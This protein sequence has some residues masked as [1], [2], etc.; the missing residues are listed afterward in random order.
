MNRTNLEKSGIILDNPYQMAYENVCLELLQLLILVEKIKA[1]KKEFKALNELVG[2]Q[3]YL[4]DYEPIQGFFRSFHYSSKTKEADDIF[5]AVC[6]V[7]DKKQKPSFNDFSI[8]AN[9]FLKK[10]RKSVR[11]GR[12]EEDEKRDE[13]WLTLAPHAINES[14]YKFSS[15]QHQALGYSHLNIVHAY[16]EIDLLLGTIDKLQ[17]TNDEEIIDTIINRYAEEMDIDIATVLHEAKRSI[18]IRHQINQKICLAYSQRFFD[19]T[20]P[21][22]KLFSIDFKPFDNHN[23]MVDSAEE[24][25]KEG[26]GKEKVGKVITMKV[27][28]ETFEHAQ[29]S[30][31]EAILNSAILNRIWDETKE[32][33]NF[34]FRDNA[35]ENYYQGILSDYAYWAGNQTSTLLDIE[36]SKGRRLT[37]QSIMRGLRFSYW[38]YAEKASR[39]GKFNI[40]DAVKFYV[41]EKKLQDSAA[42][43]KFSFEAI[44]RV[45]KTELL[46]LQRKQLVWRL[47]N[48]LTSVVYSF[49]PLNNSLYQKLKVTIDK[50]NNIIKPKVQLQEYDDIFELITKIEESLKCGNGSEYL[51]SELEFA[52]IP[53]YARDH[54]IQRRDLKKAIEHKEDLSLLKSTV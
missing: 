45:G 44:K 18:H 2:L 1:S 13:F 52:S 37:F 26:W 48:D 39:A 20:L 4:R 21:M 43:V 8:E 3:H 47:S 22:K 19:L 7:L 11:L 12:E 53:D 35:D 50:I 32:T 34:V 41:E 23:F 17:N 6:D 24:T 5:H 46:P 51:D 54:D 14:G 15:L 40:G 42:T 29:S 9:S 30:G 16:T 10:F 27:P 31:T 33:D 49:C 38:Y 28:I 25:Y 36:L